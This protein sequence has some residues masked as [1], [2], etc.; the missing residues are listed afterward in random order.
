MRLLLLTGAGL[1]VLLA[2]VSLGELSIFNSDWNTLWLVHGPRAL[3]ALGVGGIL[4]VSGALLQ[5][6]FANPLCEP[7]TLGISS[8][9][10]L[11][12]VGV[13]AL[14]L[15]PAVGGVV[16]GIA[17][18]PLAGALIFSIPIFRVAG[19]DRVTG[20]SLLLLGVMLGF[21]GSSLV[22]LVLALSPGAGVA[23]ALV[24]L[25][26]DL[27]R[28]TLGG[29][30]ATATAGVLLTAWIRR[31]HAE[32]DALLLGEASARSLGVPV[33]SVR[34]EALLVV[35]LLVAWGVALSGMIGFVGL[36]VPHFVRAWSGASHRRLLPL[37]FAMGGLCVAAADLCGRLL[38]SP[39][40]IPVGVL[41][42]LAGVPAYWLWGRRRA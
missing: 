37:A 32:L 1:L 18:G 5:A 3:L 42:A 27:S 23:R 28:A 6:L 30:V 12:A 19:R 13:A 21:F 14:G 41:T 22:A 40:E 7:Y 36:M 4:A 10:A 25:L 8:G 2:S 34:R 38:F 11:G 31:R 35:S 39:R 24:W 17:L 15:S 16:E 26:G 9:A 33:D 20:G 29:S